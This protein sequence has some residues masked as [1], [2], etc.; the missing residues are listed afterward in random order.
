MGKRCTGPCGETKPF[1]AFSKMSKAKDGRQAWC[2]E[3]AAERKKTTRKPIDPT[4]QRAADLKHLYGLTVE[5][6]DK[7]LLEQSGLCALCDEPMKSPHVDHSHT[8]GEIRALLCLQ[9]NTMLGRVERLGLTRI[10]PYLR[11]Q[12]IPIV[13]PFRWD[14]LYRRFLSSSYN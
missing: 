13:V 8:T 14:S 10:E 6:W 11:P 12:R 4:K 1:E 7:M 2:K 3:C 5:Q 9:C